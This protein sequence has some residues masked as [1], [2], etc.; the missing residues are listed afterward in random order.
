MLK[1]KPIRVYAILQVNDVRNNDVEL[2]CCYTD[3]DVAEKICKRLN[4][5]YT[6]EY[7]IVDTLLDFDFQKRKYIGK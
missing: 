1:T 4:R 3:Y 2:A 5:I 7:Y 6:Q